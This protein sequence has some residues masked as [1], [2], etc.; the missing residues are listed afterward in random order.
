LQA[1]KI[2]GRCA[3]ALYRRAQAK[4]GLNEYD[5]ALKDLRKALA[6]SKN[7][8]I[9]QKEII[10]LKKVM[11]D[12]LVTEKIRCKRMFKGCDVLK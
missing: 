10:C 7:D 11:L 4:R 1:L 2:D 6:L 9:I 3:K 8:K 5:A 12:Y